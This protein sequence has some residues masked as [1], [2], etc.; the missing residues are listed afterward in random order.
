MHF[1]LF[2]NIH[3]PVAMVDFFISI[4]NYKIWYT[5][6]LTY[7]IAWN[8]ES[9]ITVI[10][11]LYICTLVIRLPKKTTVSPLHSP[12][13]PGSIIALVKYRLYIIFSTEFVMYFIPTGWQHINRALWIQGNR[14]LIYSLWSLGLELLFKK[15]LNYVDIDYDNDNHSLYIIIHVSSVASYDHRSHMW[16]QCLL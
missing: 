16:I 10:F 12:M 3:I 14:I 5:V 11:S 15:I 9:W 4:N 8:S 6:H 2:C 13:S 1:K 7:K